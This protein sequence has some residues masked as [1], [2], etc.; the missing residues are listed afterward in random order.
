MSDDWMRSKETSIDAGK[1][2]ALRPEAEKTKTNGRDLLMW[3]LIFAIFP[4]GA[5]IRHLL[6]M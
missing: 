5:L 2:E 4:I 6:L 3:T 1:W